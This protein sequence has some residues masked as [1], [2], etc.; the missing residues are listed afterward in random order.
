MSSQASTDDLDQPVTR[1]DVLGL[2]DAITELA[3]TNTWRRRAWIMVGA[4]AIFSVVLAGFSWH[5][6]RSTQQG[7]TCIRQWAVAT[8]VR[9]AILTDARSD[10]DD[11]N[12]DLILTLVPVPGQTKHQQAELFRARLTDYTEKAKAYRGLRASHPLPASPTYSC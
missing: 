10:L 1:R 2:T 7:F 12:S 6:S 4:L 9:S 3:G 8:S 11:A 5:Q